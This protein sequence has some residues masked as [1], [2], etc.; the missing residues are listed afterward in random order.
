MPG[1]LVALAVILIRVGIR[2]IMLADQPIRDSTI[3][4]LPPPVPGGGTPGGCIALI[5]N[6]LRQPNQ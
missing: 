2:D 1:S 3:I 6:R 4:Q 5:L